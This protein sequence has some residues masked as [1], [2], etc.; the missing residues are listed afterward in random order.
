M[1]TIYTSTNIKETLNYLQKRYSNLNNKKYSIHEIIYAF[2]KLPGKYKDL[3]L[4]NNKDE[5]DKANLSH[6]YD[7]FR[8]T[9][10]V[11]KNAPSDI[12]INIK[13]IKDE[14]KVKKDSVTLEDV[15]FDEPN[16]TKKNNESIDKREK[17]N[18]QVKKDN[19]KEKNAVNQ[20]IKFVILEEYISERQNVNVE[21]TLDKLSLDEDEK[22][23]IMLKYENNNVKTNEEVSKELGVCVS[24]IDE[25]VDK[26]LEQSIEYKKKKLL[27][28]ERK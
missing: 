9:L 5:N 24:Y 20:K 12:K 11:T 14:E 1:K 8:K 27:T 7:H 26:Y 25:V 15:E 23:I 22:F 17:Y 28:L 3:L 10:L 13:N 21:S 6:V 16:R 2:N 19:N 18:N 4:K